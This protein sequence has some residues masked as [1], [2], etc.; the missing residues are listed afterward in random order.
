MSAPSAPRS[1]PARRAY[2]LDTVQG[3]GA[4]HPTGARTTVPAG[5]PGDGV[6][7]ALQRTAGNR[8]VAALVSSRAVVVQRKGG[9]RPLDDEAAQKDFAAKVAKH[10]KGGKS[11]AQA[12]FLAL[13]RHVRRT[14]CG[15][16]GQANPEVR[17]AGRERHGDVP[18]GHVADQL[19]GHSRSTPGSIQPPSTTASTTAT[20]TPST[21]ARSR[22]QA[23]LKGI[24]KKVP[25]E[26]GDLAGKS[27]YE[28]QDLVAGGIHFAPGQPFGIFPSW[29]GDDEM[30]TRLKDYA[31]LAAGAKVKVGD[32]VVYSAG[33]ALP[34]SGRVIAVDTKGRPTMIRSKWGHYSLFE[35]PPAAVPAHYG[36]PSYH[37]KK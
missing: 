29:V 27:F 3:S 34:H 37:R 4:G 23:Q 10:Q 31:P 32:I 24:V 21:R 26:G 30:R 8:K 28:A 17:H 22:S 20:A 9:F 14:G 2:G 33:S 15:G 7:L 35:H 6:Y 13:G 19:R 5:P 36:T 18:H 16:G 12:A 25:K 11:Q 1:P